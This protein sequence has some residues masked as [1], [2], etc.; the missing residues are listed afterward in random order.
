MFVEVLERGNVMTGIY[1][2]T[3]VINGKSYIGQSVDIK[4]RYKEH[5]NRKDENTLFHAAIKEYGFENFVFSIIEVCNIDELNDK[6]IFYI[7]EYN[8]L[9][10][11]GYNVSEG[12]HH[13]HPMKLSSVDDVSAII[14][15]LK[16]TDMTNIEIGSLYEV[17]DQTVS[18]INNGRIWRNDSIVYPIRDRRTPRKYCQS[19]GKELYKYTQGDLCRECILNLPR[20]MRYKKEIPITK[21]ELLEL[22][23]KN[24]FAFIGRM[25]GVSDNTV[26]VWCDKYNIPRH[27][28]YYKKLI[29]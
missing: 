11:N 29:S 1:K 25:F 14:Y 15:L 10:P 20:H 3:N 27:S 21:D 2:F 12:G 19:C 16:N 23:Y 7:K 4:R 9:I 17:S 6:E 26:R 13:G 8:T 24:S 22:L 5:K 18:D 28:K